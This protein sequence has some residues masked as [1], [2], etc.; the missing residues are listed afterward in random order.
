MS[1]APGRSSEAHAQAGETAKPTRRHTVNVAELRQRLGQRL[2][3]EIDH[4]HEPVQVVDTRTERRPIRGAVVIESIER[5]V[6]VAGEVTFAWSGDCRRCLDRVEG[7]AEIDIF[8]VFQIDADPDDSEINPLEADVVDLVPIVR[9]AVVLGLPLAP[10][11][12]EDCAGPDPDR[13]PAKT[14]EEVEAEAAAAPPV[15]DP[16]WAALGDLS[17]DQ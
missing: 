10:L 15:P 1:E 17:F 14:I 9:D 5:G 4:L 11:C 16:R 8:E 2:E 7:D 6:T 13:Y 3:I 12:G